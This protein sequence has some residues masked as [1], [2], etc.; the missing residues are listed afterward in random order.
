[1]V[2]LSLQPQ[3]AVPD[4]QLTAEVEVPDYVQQWIRSQQE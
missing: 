1:V 4:S 3:E 2:P